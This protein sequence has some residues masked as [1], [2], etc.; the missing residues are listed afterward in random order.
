[1]D[2]V[3]RTPP[4]TTKSLLAALRPLTELFGVPPDE[5][6]ALAF[7]RFPVQGE[8]SYVHD[9]WFPRFGPAWRLH[10]GTDIFAPAGTPVRAPAAG[11]LTLTMNGLGGLSAYVTEVD[12][13]YHYLAHLAGY[14]P[15]VLSGQAVR[16]GQVVGY[17]GNSGN[18]RTTPP[19]L[20]YEFHPRGGPAVD[21]K[22]HLDGWLEG[23]VAGV[24][25]LL[26]RF[27]RRLPRVVVTTAAT[28]GFGPSGPSPVGRLAAAA[29]TGALGVAVLEAE[30]AAA[31]VDWAPI[32][33]A[34]QQRAADWAA[35]EKVATLLVDPVTPAPLRRAL[36]PGSSGTA[37][38]ARSPRP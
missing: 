23:A 1:M 26:G 12:G 28:R 8:A 33:R 15:D 3:P 2:S 31:S 4:S 19:H 35:R 29:W 27:E 6:A 11:T 38:E 37:E 25:G 18:A 20:H 36:S 10:Q 30:R 21:P 17:V 24:S 22:P 16:L 32:E 34:A 13:T 9:W 7:G 14:A 5:A